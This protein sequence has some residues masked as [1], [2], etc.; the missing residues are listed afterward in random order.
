MDG[1]GRGDVTGTLRQLVGFQP[2]VAGVEV[3]ATT[4]TVSGGSAR[5]GLTTGFGIGGGVSVRGQATRVER[6]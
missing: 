2:Q 5:A 4:G 3:S 6:G 1:L